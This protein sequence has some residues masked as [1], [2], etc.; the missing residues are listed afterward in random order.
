M[1]PGRQVRCG[2]LLA[3]LTTCIV[4]RGTLAAQ[5]EPALHPVRFSEGV[6]HGFL[7]L[8]SEGDTLLAHGELIQVPGD[9]TLV[10]TIRFFFRDGSRFEETAE[11]TQHQSFRLKH[12]HLIER[13]PAFAFDLDATLN[14]D[15]GYSFSSQSHDKDKPEQDQGRVEAKTPLGNGLPLILAKNL[16]AGDS[17]AIALVAFTPKPQLITLRVS[18]AGKDSILVGGHSEALAHWTLTPDVGGLKGFFAKLLGKL[19]DPTQVWVATEGAPT[20]VRVT[21]PLYLGPVWRIDLSGAR[22]PNEE[23]A[24]SATRK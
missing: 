10:S 9:S 8:H 6:V 3:L 14:A 22:W 23:H 18:Y 11:F 2:P 12:Y 1:E 16:K 4:S 21:G 7:E 19:P 24:A 13:G 20:I 15:G 17:T 5:Q